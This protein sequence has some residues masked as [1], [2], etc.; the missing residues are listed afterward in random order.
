MDETRN[1]DH[2]AQ[3]DLKFGPAGI[4]LQDDLALP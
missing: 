3:L 2:D 1:R 4:K